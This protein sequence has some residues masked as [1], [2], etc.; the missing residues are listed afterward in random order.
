MRDISKRIENAEKKLNLSKK[1]ITIKIVCF[2]GELPPDRVEGSMTCQFVM[3]DGM[4]GK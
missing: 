2:G 4:K 1:P 3:Y